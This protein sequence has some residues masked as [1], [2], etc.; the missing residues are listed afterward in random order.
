LNILSS[1]L[2]FWSNWWLPLHILTKNNWISSIYL[3]FWYISSH[4]SHWIPILSIWILISHCKI[5]QN[6]FSMSIIQPNIPNIWRKILRDHNYYD[7]YH[8]I[9]VFSLFLLLIKLYIFH[10]KVYTIS[11]FQVSIL[12]FKHSIWS[13]IDYL[14]IS[15]AYW[16]PY[17]KCLGHTLLVCRTKGTIRNWKLFVDWVWSFYWL[18]LYKYKPVLQLFLLCFWCMEWLTNCQLLTLCNS[19]DL[20]Y[21]VKHHNLSRQPSVILWWFNR[22]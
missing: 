8:N 5:Q 16:S 6:Y 17:P 3:L 9:L 22:S 14:N 1:L 2:S 15:W 13:Y 20:G 21:F 19:F 7:P 11:D 18:T 4:T 10:F 12:N